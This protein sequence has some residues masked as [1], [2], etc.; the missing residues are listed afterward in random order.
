MK[1]LI[2]TLCCLLLIFNVFANDATHSFSLTTDFA[3]YPDSTP[4][5]TGEDSDDIVRF[6][7]ITGPYKSL[8]ARAVVKHSYKIPIRITCTISHACTFSATAFSYN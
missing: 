2:F 3:F 6:S 8:E 4:V 5:V 1:K 7:P